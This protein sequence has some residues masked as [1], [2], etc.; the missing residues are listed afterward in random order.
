MFNASDYAKKL[1]GH[2]LMLNMLMLGYAYEK[3]RLPIRE[4][5]MMQAI[6]ANGTMINDNKKAWNM[7]R[8]IGTVEGKKTIDKVID[9]KFYVTRKET[10][11]GDFL[12]LIHI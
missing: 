12:S 4:H 5:S 3:A 11:T 6:E 8:H 1:T 2:S 9:D 10:A 7:G